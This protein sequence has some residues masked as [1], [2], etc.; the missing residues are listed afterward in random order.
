LASDRPHRRLRQIILIVNDTDRRLRQ[1]MSARLPTHDVE[2][3][4]A[5]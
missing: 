4:T 2:A 1:V 5:K 3:G